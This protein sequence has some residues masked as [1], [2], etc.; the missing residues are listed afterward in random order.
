MA[1]KTQHHVADLMTLY[2]ATFFEF[3]LAGVKWGWGV[4]EEQE[5]AEAAWKGYDAWVRLTSASIDDLY[6]N[7]LFGDLMARSLDGVLRWQRLSQALVGPF[8]GLW[9]A[10]GLPTAAAVQVLHEE[11]QSLTARLKA[12][13]AQIQALGEEL[14][15]PAADLPPQ[16]KRRAPST[17]LDALLKP[18]QVKTNGHQTVTAPL[19]PV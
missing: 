4:G 16:K 7:P 5:V 10:V 18:M 11:V 9:P 6:R 19:T 13:D 3:P 14:R 17:K 12:Q 2:T 15:S 1:E 8:A